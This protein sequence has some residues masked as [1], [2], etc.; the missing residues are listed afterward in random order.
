MIADARARM[1]KFVLG[2]S[3]MVVKE[4]R[5]T[6]IVNDMEIFCLIFHAQNI[7]E[8]KHNDRYREAERVKT[9]MLISHIQ[10]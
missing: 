9:V 10:G 1:S 3:K 8:E 7:K 2:V 6:M 4:C 5:I